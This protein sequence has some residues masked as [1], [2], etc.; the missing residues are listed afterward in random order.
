MK[1]F[2]KPVND[3]TCDMCGKQSESTDI[4]S[5][6]EELKISFNSNFKYV[7]RSKEY[8]VCDDCTPN[9]L[10]TNKPDKLFK[11]LL[12]KIGVLK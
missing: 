4:P 12:F 10:E 2:N 11:K 6:W 9:W 5:G 8:D 3:Y 7:A 1:K